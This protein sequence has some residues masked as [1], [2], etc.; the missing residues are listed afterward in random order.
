MVAMEAGRQT[1]ASAVDA[2]DSRAAEDPDQPIPSGG[3]MLGAIRER[4]SLWTILALLFFLGFVLS[5]LIV[6]S[7]RS[8]ALDSVAKLAQDDAQ[9]IA[10]ILT[11]DQLTKPIT[12]KSYDEL[13]G[14]IRKTATRASVVGVTVW[15]SEGRILFSRDQS[16]V[17]TTPTDMQQFIV[18]LAQ[19][20]G[21][22][23]VVDGIVQTFL[24]ISKSAD[25]PV[26]VVEL[27]QPY[28]LVEA[29]IGN[30]WSLV[31]LMFA[32]GLF[33][34]LLLLGAAFVSSR[35]LSYSAE[36][37]E[38][39]VAGDE[40]DVHAEAVDMETAPVDMEAASAGMKKDER[41]EAASM[42]AES[43][44]EETLT[45][46]PAPAVEMD[47]Q[48]PAVEEEVPVSQSD[49]DVAVHQ[50]QDMAAD[51]QLQELVRRREEIKARAKEA[52]LRFKK[53][54]AQLQETPSTPR[55]EQ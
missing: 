27:D 40:A 24:P 50:E 4:R 30:F 22:T 47:S 5:T 51:M 32:L 16:L 12:G 13:R 29:R 48:V 52:K 6:R 37:D 7:E 2:S 8:R 10:A 33:I 11:K 41:D 9:L 44:P 53:R 3:G 18:E 55:S 23:R 1:A 54:G 14:K 19:G 46:E 35:R 21:G 17:G 15:S 31:R 39:H 38:W 20:Q 42:Q 49:K 25:G 45:S 34:S 28:A 36:A 26:A 43:H